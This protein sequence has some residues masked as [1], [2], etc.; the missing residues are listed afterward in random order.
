MYMITV[1][2]QPGIIASS[3]AGPYGQQERATQLALAST[4]ELSDISRLPFY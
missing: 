4:V 3:L 2:Y 1:Q